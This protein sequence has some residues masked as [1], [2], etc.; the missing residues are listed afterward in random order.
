[1][2]ITV[3][4]RHIEISDAFRS[5]VESGIEELT[6]KHNISPIETTVTLAKQ[7]HTFTADIDSHIAQGLNIRTRGEGSDAYTC[8]Q[9]ALDKLK[10]RIRR[11]KSW[12]DDHHRHRDIPVEKASSFILD[13]EQ[14][15]NREE[16]S[17]GYAPAIIAEMQA[18]VPTLTVGEAVNRFDV[19]EDHAYIFRN[20]KSGALNVIYRRTDGNIGW[21][22]PT[23]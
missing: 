22:D 5:N 3:T 15:T 12:L 1:M 11:H 21:V 23:L 19:A 13:A 2:I 18:D 7:N 14:P 10:A 20:S 8:F 16:T 6:S 9:N 4:G 17:N